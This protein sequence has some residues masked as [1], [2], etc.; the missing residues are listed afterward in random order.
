M[1]PQAFLDEV[2]RAPAL[3]TGL[4]SRA[5]ILYAARF[6]PIDGFRYY[7]GDTSTWSAKEWIPYGR[8]LTDLCGLVSADD[9]VDVLRILPTQIREN[10]RW[11]SVRDL[12]TDRVLQF[13]DGDILPPATEDGVRRSAELACTLLPEKPVE[14]A[15]VAPVLLTLNRHSIIF[16]NDRMSAAIERERAKGA[17]VIERVLQPLGKVTPRRAQHSALWKTLKQDPIWLAAYETWK[18]SD[19]CVQRGVGLQAALKDTVVYG[20]LWEITPAWR[21]HKHWTFASRDPSI[22]TMPTELRSAIPAAKDHVWVQFSF[23]TPMVRHKAAM[24][25][26][27]MV[28]PPSAGIS[29]DEWS[30]AYGFGT[31]VAYEAILDQRPDEEK[32]E[33]YEHARELNA[34]LLRECALGFDVKGAIMTRGAVVVHLHRECDLRGFM[35]HL[36]STL[37]TTPTVEAWR[38]RG[39]LEWSMSAG[40]SWG[41]LTPLSSEPHLWSSELQIR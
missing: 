3:A 39:V 34:W 33:A 37:I 9:L 8:A 19:L 16:D 30:Q 17:E 22:N 5:G 6:H 23:S 15:V 25:V 18:R 32:F 20:N 38:S 35:G 7:G 4:A 28:P 41:E 36:A 27:S 14:N 29:L 12:H 10:I 1:T 21:F 24:T 31:A 2:Q 40:P 13:G 11:G 26:S